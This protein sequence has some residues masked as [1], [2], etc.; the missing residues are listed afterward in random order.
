[1]ERSEDEPVDENYLKT[2]LSNLESEQMY[3]KCAIV[4]ELL[5]IYDEI[6]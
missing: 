4:K 6:C 2:T 3:E 1:M 5:D